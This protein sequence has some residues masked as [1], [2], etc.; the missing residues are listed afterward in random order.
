MSD[1][2][3]ALQARLSRAKD[4]GA[5][6]V[7]IADE[8]QAQI[9]RDTAAQRAPG[10]DQWQERKGAGA[11]ML[12]RVKSNIKRTVTAGVIV[13]RLRGH[14]ALHDLGKAKGNVQRRLLPTTL[15][16]NVRSAV[17]RWLK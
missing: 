2:L 13:F 17:D 3:D 11:K 15:D 12:R 4:F 14:Y 6:A 9:E 10:G 1:V 16:A 5:L 7:V 8:V